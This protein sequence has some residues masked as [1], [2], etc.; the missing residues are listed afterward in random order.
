VTLRDCFKRRKCLK[1]VHG[2]DLVY[3]PAFSSLRDSP[4][5]LLEIGILKGASV[6]AWLDYFPRA[7]IVAVDTFDRV[8]SAQVP[9]L[10]HPRVM[11]I[12]GDSATVSVEGK[13]DIIVDDGW[14]HPIHQR[15][16]FCNLIAHLAGVYFIE[17]VRP[18]RQEFAELMQ[19][20]S[21]YKVK[22][23]DLRRGRNP[24]SYLIEIRR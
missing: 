18:D 7:E 20:L 16:T 23:H 15:D 4:I 14:H 12:E 1:L 2:Y 9:V 6:S 5:R 22:C 10:D 3:E 13:F 24:D 21:G 8:P 19:A 17:D 11:W